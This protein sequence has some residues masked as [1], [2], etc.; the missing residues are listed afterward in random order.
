MSN[1]NVSSSSS[2][3]HVNYSLK[4]ILLIKG[5]KY[6]KH[7]FFIDSNTIYQKKKKKIEKSDKRLVFQKSINS[8]ALIGHC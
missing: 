5:D 2:Q 6:I 7:F 1:D 4:K 3:K 8:E